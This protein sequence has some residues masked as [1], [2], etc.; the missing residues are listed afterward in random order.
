ME[1]RKSE[2]LELSLPVT[3]SFSGKLSPLS[4]QTK[5]ISSG[6]VYIE[7]DCILPPATALSLEIQLTPIDNNQNN[8][9]TFIQLKGQV[10]RS[11]AKGMAIQFIDEHRFFRA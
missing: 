4:L 2:R 6:G 8:K 1:K 5:N 7:T 3:V 11:S 10:L 9:K